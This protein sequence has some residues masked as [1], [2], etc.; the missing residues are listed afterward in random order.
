MWSDGAVSSVVQKTWNS[1]AFVMEASVSLQL[2]A[3][4]FGLGFSCTWVCSSL[5]F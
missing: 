3:A 5:V 1:F 4:F 2:H